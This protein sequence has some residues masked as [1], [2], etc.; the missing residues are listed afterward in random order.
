[1]KKTLA[2]IIIS[3]FSL[4]LNSQP[5][6]NLQDTLRGSLNDNRNWFDI[7]HYNITVTPSYETKSIIGQV[8][9]TAK[10]V[11]TSNNIQIDLQQPLIIDS[12]IYLAPNAKSGKSLT[13]SRNDNVA[14]V[15]F[16]EKLN[17]NANFRLVIY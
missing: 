2:I 4:A 15:S 3:F 16:N 14:I 5:V 12:V 17:K 1:M 9:W 13:Y 8:S 11:K 7:Q 6:F 10:V